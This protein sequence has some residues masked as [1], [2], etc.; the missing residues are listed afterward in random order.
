MPAMPDFLAHLMDGKNDFGLGLGSSA[1]EKAE[2]DTRWI[3]EFADDL[4]VAI[5]LRKWDQAVT[6][7][8]EGKSP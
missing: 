7:L 2:R 5:A 3:A 4:T 1:K 6:L 8:E